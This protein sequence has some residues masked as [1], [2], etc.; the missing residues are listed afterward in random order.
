VHILYRCQWQKCSHIKI[1]KVQICGKDEVDM[2]SYTYEH[3]YVFTYIYIYVYSE[4]VNV[5]DI[6]GGWDGWHM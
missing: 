6:V 3:A 2:Y 4:M 5:R 1:F